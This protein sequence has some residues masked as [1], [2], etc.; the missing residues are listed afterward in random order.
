MR[1]KGLLL[2]LDLQGDIAPRIAGR[3]LSQGLLLNAPRPDSLRFMPAL[4][5]TMAEIDAMIEVLDGVLA[6]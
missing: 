4:N 3:A 5:V 1:G 6:G 2:A